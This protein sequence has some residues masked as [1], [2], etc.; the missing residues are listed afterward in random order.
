LCVREWNACSTKAVCETPF[1]RLQREYR[2]KRTGLA[3]ETLAL[4]NTNL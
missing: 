2:N 4:Y 3:A 1:L